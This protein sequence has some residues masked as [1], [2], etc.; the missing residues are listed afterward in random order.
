M[1]EAEILAEVRRAESILR[2]AESLLADAIEAER[3]I[4]TAAADA[5]AL[6]RLALNGD[7]VTRSP[8]RIRSARDRLD[9]MRRLS[10]A[11]G[12]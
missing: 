9:E 3:D 5:L 2:Q 11:R 4:P 7:P 1:T 10:V 12:G 8:R 6:I